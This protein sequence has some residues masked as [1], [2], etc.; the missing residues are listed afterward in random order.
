[1]PEWIKK[2]DPTLSY[3]DFKYQ[4]IGSLKTKIKMQN[5]AMVVQTGDP[6]TQEGSRTRPVWDT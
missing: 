2:H 6:S 3:P 1:L 5:W 4:D